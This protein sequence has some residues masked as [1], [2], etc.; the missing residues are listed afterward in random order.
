M[1]SSIKFS[2][3]DGWLISG[4][5]LCKF[6]CNYVPEGGIAW[7]LRDL[8][9]FACEKCFRSKRKVGKIYGFGQAIPAKIVE[10][11]P[12]ELQEE[13]PKLEWNKNGKITRMDN[14]P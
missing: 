12:K 14:S 6:C 11:L 2:K 10:E 9:L 3:R 8:E 4:N 5:V 7:Y 1:K 13:E